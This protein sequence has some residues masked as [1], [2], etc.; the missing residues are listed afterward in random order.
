MHFQKTVKHELEKLIEQGHLEKADKTTENCFISSA[1]I[2]IKKDKSVKIALDS[3]KINEAC[4]KK[5][6]A[7]PNMEEI[8]SKI[9][10]ETT[11]NNGEIICQKLTWIMLMGRQNYSKKHQNIVC[12]Q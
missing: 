7:I 1:V 12:S 4:V 8:I 5:K 10:A 2:T 3:R 11:K 9:S 6:A